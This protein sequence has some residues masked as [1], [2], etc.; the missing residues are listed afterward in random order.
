MK[1]ILFYFKSIQG[2][3]TQSLTTWTIIVQWLNV[4]IRLPLRAA[5]VCSRLLDGKW[6][7]RPGSFLA[8]PFDFFYKM[9]IKSP[10]WICHIGVSQHVWVGYLPHNNFQIFKKRNSSVVFLAVFSEYSSA[11]PLSESFKASH[12]GE[13]E[14]KRSKRLIIYFVQYKQNKQLIY[15]LAK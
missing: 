2:P 10:F 11:G 4:L 14:N 6:S 3:I 15:V 12:T 7:Q 1:A 13:M 5:D 8:K 9:L